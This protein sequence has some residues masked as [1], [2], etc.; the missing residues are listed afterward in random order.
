[1]CL[2]SAM[3]LCSA[4]SIE[5]TYAT[6]NTCHTMS[7]CQH[8]LSKGSEGP[9]N[10]PGANGVDG[11]K[12]PQFATRPHQAGRRLQVGG[13]PGFFEVRGGS[14]KA[15]EKSSIR[16]RSGPY[17]SR[18]AGRFPRQRMAHADLQHHGKPAQ[19]QP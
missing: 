1:M 10:A 3:L 6:V 14:L 12:V 2:P 8:A 7:H 19:W 17:Q 13:A 11:R 15:P 18:Y 16:A 9:K 4:S 5:V